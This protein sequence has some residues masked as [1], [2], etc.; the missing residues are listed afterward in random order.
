M[1]RLIAVALSVA[2]G[3]SFGQG[4]RQDVVD[5][6]QAERE[7]WFYGQRA[8][9]LGRIPTGARLKAL[10][11]IDR[12]D[13]EARTSGLSARSLI[14]GGWTSIGPQ[15]TN[16][17][18]QF[19]TAG[20]VNS[21]AIDP[22]N[23]NTIYIGAA[24]GGVWKTT[25]GGQ[26]WLPLTDA[27]SSLANGAIALDPSHPEIIYVGTGEENFAIDSYYG[28]GILKSTDGG[29]SWKNIVGPFLHAYIGSIAVNPS[30]SQVLLLSS[31]TGIW[32]SNDAA[33]SWTKVLDGTG[34][35]VLFDPTNGEVAYAA[36]G[37]PF[38]NF[39]N[40]VY[41]ST[42]GGQTWQS[43]RGSS[44]NALPSTRVGRIS[45]AIAPSAPSTLYAA[46]HDY[47]T[48][49]LIDIFK[50]TDSGN[51]WNPTHAPDICAASGQCWYDMTL[52]VQPSNS[53]V[54]FA[55]GQTSIIRT[56][57]GGGT[58]EP[59]YFIGPD[60]QQYIHPD[61]HDLQFTPDGS[62]LY[63]ANDGG[64]YTT[65]DIT[66]EGVNWTELN[67]ALSITQFYPGVAIAP[68]DINTALAGTQDN[69]LQLH[70]ANQ[71]WWLVNCGDGGYSAIS[72][73]TS[74]TACVSG[75]IV[76][77]S[78]DG[79]NTWLPSQYGINSKDRAQ[80]VP[81]FIM[82]PSNSQTLYFGT[83]RVWQTRDGAGQWIP[84]SHDLTGGQDATIQAI[85]VAPSDPNVVYAGTSDGLVKTTQNAL[86]GSSATWVN[87]SSGLPGR[88]VTSIA[89]DPI[90]SGTA[91]V[92]YSGF[93]D[94]T[95]KPS[96]HV[97]KTTNNGSTW[98]DISGN[99]PD[100]PVNSLAID[101]DLPDTLYIGTDGGMMVST[102]GGGSWST[103]GNGFPKV[104]VLSVVLH[105]ASRT[106][107]AATH[108]RGVW[109][110][111]IPLSST[112]ASLAP[113]IAS[114]SP[115]GANVGSGAF[116]LEVSG[117]NFG[118]ETKLR[119]NG[120]ART[121][122]VVNST[123]LTADI[124]AAD[125]ANVGLVSVDAFSSSNGG[126]ASNALP[127]NIG[128]GPAGLAAVNAASSQPG[129]AP[130]S[131]ATLYGTNLAGMTESADAA[132]PLPLTLG[133]ATLSMPN[134]PIALF[135]VSPKQINFQVPF[136]PV[137]ESTQ[138]SLTLTV[139]QLTNTFNITLVPYAPA[140]FTTN[141]QGTGQAAA[142]DGTS[143]AAPLGAF[144]GSHPASKGDIVALYCTGLGNVSNPPDPGFPAPSDPLSDTLATP[145]VT[146]G[147]QPALAPFSG[148]A[149]GYVGLYQVNIQIPNS[150]PSGSAI[151][152]VL[153]IG[154][155]Q[156]NTATIA[157]Q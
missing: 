6:Q 147:G 95:R 75:D 39:N 113:V 2:G 49:S 14:A 134:S 85:A 47:A 72:T 97:F 114:F 153:N 122:H 42:D 35:A 130:G 32:R 127:F 17:G 79:A 94:S 45:L 129:L 109:D 51:I 106:L 123:R 145:T 84:I 128:P 101:P 66:N 38:G 15:P 80:F 152:V 141:S 133:G 102:N 10:A 105:R 52:R 60:Y 41:R 24:E 73:I 28:A 143:L 140:L 107:R 44:V 144:P 27:Q 56:L 12:I 13:L 29:A 53:N 7:A 5:D 8:Y 119:W 50:T 89:I 11:E 21:I 64:M 36:L 43:I 117:A 54:V 81:P 90:D 103:L 87:S 136:G 40:G 151:P 34:T 71:G 92:T 146:V 65:S 57:D 88:A 61:Y 124:T 111:L 132:P 91:Y 121:T 20:R 82:D 4:R 30:N 62:V 131:I 108:G 125:I 26:S 46:L 3:L 120:Q 16:P 139:G 48:G 19:V 149:P 100:L 112:S 118:A 156:S 59:L 99:L 86:S 150:A 68:A 96:A 98:V 23:S 18:S 110:I 137:F 70:Q 116:T 78:T 93:I 104:V 76:D 126:G 9:P 22:T 148:L 74:F 157:I 63:I 154:G 31:D 138:T 25:D 33:A 55:G 115:S 155:V 142:L 58:W 67:D 69:G 1:K 135:Y 37:D 77:R 83:F